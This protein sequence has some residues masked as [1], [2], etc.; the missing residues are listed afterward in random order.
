MQKYDELRRAKQPL[1]LPSAGSTFKRPRSKDGKPLYAAA[2]MEECG[3]KGYSVGGAAVSDKHAGFVV[4]RGGAS[5]DDMLRLIG[6]IK[7]EVFR[8]SGVEIEPE[9]KI[10]GDD[11]KWMFL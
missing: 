1:E 4:N 7:N 3:L 8:Q 5:F 6:H 10:I 2:L 11:G 9:I